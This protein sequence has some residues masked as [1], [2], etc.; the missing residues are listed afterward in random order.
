MSGTEIAYIDFLDSDFVSLRVRQTGRSFRIHRKLLQSKSRP[1]IA[2][3]DSTL[4]EG[5]DSLYEFE[6]VKEGTVA[7]FIEWAY[8]GD[9]PT[10]ITLLEPLPTPFIPDKV[11]TDIEDKPGTKSPET[12]FTS[13]NHPLLVHVRLYIFSHIY[14]IPELQKLAYEKA[15]ACFADLDKPDGLDRQLAVIDALRLS[16]SRL[17]HEDTL[18]DWLAQYAAYSIDKLRLQGSFHD[19]LKDFPALSSRMMISLSPAQSPPWR[20]TQQKHQ[21]TQYS[22]RWTGDNYDL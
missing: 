12:D 15:T 9:Y 4:K 13:E 18:L 2:A 11:D 16:F 10:S 3:L 21:F 19:L 17:S 6:D 8:R 22:A 7:R 5:R 20:S 1:L 14:I